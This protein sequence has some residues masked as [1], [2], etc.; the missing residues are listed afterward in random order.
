MDRKELTEERIS[1]GKKVLIG[2]DRTHF[3]TAAAFWF[4]ASD[5]TGWRY[6]VATHLLDELGPIQTYG[7]LQKELTKILGKDSVFIKE[8]SIVS[9]AHPLVGLLR[10]ALRTEPEVIS[11]IRFTGNVINGQYIDDAYL[12][13]VS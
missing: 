2:L 1:L 6:I 7:R 12:Y 4:L 9:P 11:G 13:R 3:P 8:I 10:L 5:S